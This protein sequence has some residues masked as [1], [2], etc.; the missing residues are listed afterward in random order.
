MVESNVPESTAFTARVRPSSYKHVGM[1]RASSRR[2]NRKKVLFCAFYYKSSIKTST[3]SSAPV[4]SAADPTAPIGRA[5]LSNNPTKN[6][7]YSS[8]HQVYS[9][10]ADAADRNN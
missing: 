1:R 10:A 8:H 2:W 4:A 5:R 3:V 9:E 6:V 7:V